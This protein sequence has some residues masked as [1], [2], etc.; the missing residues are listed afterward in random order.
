MI[1]E[2]AAVADSVRISAAVTILAAEGITG[3][4]IAAAE[5]ITGA[6]TA[7]TGTTT[8]VISKRDTSLSDPPVR[9]AGNNYLMC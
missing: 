5:G 3:A 6:A 4:A 1:M 8:T 7:I 9:L 2:L